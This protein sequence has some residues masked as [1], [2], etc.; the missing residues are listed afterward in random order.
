[1]SFTNRTM[2]SKRISTTLMQLAIAASPL[3]L[4]GM[5]ADPAGNAFGVSS[6]TVATPDRG[7][8]PATDVDTFSVI[9]AN[10][11]AEG[12]SNAV[13]FTEKG[14]AVRMATGDATLTDD[15]NITGM[16]LVLDAAPNGASELIAYEA[17]LNGGASLPALGL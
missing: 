7:G 5:A 17:A 6:I 4:S 3:S 10:G 9:D 2:K 11:A 14:A 15:G 8:N 12:T 13:T 1:M 16:M